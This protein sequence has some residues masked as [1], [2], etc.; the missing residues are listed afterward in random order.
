MKEKLFITPEYTTAEEILKDL[1]LPF[2]D[3]IMIIEKT[4]GRMAEDNFWIC[5][6]R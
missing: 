4:E 1:G 2:Y 3:P 5:I 6:E